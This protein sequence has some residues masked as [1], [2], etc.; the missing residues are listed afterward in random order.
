MTPSST[1]DQQT[2][3]KRSEMM[4]PTRILLITFQTHTRALLSVLV[5][6]GVASV[7]PI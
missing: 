2:H 6:F 7:T 3:H 4:V 5:L 1:R